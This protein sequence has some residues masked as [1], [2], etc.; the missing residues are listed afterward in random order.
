M[1]SMV[2]AKVMHSEA[3]GKGYPPMGI[4]EAARCMSRLL[5]WSGA[6]WLLGLDIR[7]LGLKVGL[8]TGQPAA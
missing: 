3:L 2:T 6:G 5:L 8:M 7:F 1:N 4:V